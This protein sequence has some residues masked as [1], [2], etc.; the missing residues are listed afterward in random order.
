CH[1]RYAPIRS[2][3]R[4]WIQPAGRVWKSRISREC[5]SLNARGRR[6]LGM[7]ESPRGGALRGAGVLADGDGDRGL[8]GASAA[9]VEADLVAHFD[10]I[11]VTGA[12]ERGDDDVERR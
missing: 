2:M 12:V 1:Q 3:G 6:A 4:P 10:W 9:V 5:T 7:T 8:A 11:G